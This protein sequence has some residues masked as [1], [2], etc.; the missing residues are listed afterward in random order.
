M[1][2]QQRVVVEMSGGI[3]N[4]LFQYAAALA[5][6]RRLRAR[7]ILDVSWYRRRQDPTRSRVFQL[8]KVMNLGEIERIERPTFAPLRRTVRFLDGSKVLTDNRI[9]PSQLALVDDKTDLVMRGYWQSES[10]FS[11]VAELLRNS[12]NQV[13]SEAILGLA[14]FR[15]QLGP[16]TLGLHVR[17]GDY[18]SDP[19]TN[20]FHGLCDEFYFDRAVNLVCGKCAVDRVV[21]FSDD[22]EWCKKTLK[23]QLSHFFVDDAIQDIDQFVLLS[24]CKHHVISNSSFSWWAA[25]LGQSKGQLVVYPQRWFSDGRR[26]ESMPGAWVA[27]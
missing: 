24:Q 1:A 17:R 16:E 26:L 2:R 22:I 10:Y 14:H 19:K 15:T 6:S 20:F 27:A 18:E 4:Q 21:I 12:F 13:K 5:L 9:S 25:W 8:D 23:F 7:L 11:E 3:G